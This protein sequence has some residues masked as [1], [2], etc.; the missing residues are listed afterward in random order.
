MNRTLARLILVCAPLCTVIVGCDDKS[1]TAPTDKTDKVEKNAKSDKAEEAKPKVGGAGGTTKT[2][3]D[4]V[5]LIERDLSSRG[6]EWKGIA[7]D[8][9][10]EAKVMDDMGDCRLAADGH[11][12]YDLVLSQKKDKSTVAGYKKWLEETAK[13][14]KGKVTFDKETDSSLE[15]TME[16]PKFDNEKE[17]FTSKKWFMAVKVGTK[18]VGCMPHD[19]A[20][21]ETYDMLKK[22][23]GTVRAAK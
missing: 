1:K 20:D 7:V 3:D 6:P 15:Y 8:G 22:A 12:A 9:P 13:I 21:K 16:T 10:K 17:F 14:V 2:D 11:G 23:C 4:A 19:S 5:E 18:T